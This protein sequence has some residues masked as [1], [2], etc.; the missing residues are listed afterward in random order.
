MQSS[1]KVRKYQKSSVVG[2]EKGPHVS[3]WTRSKAFLDTWFVF[4]KG[5]IFCFAIGQIVQV[6][7]SLLFIA[8]WGIQW[9]RSNCLEMEGCPNVA[10]H[11]CTSWHLF[12][13]ELKELKFAGIAAAEILFTQETLEANAGI[14]KDGKLLMEVSSRYRMP[15]ALPNPTVLHGCKPWMKQR[16]S[17]NI[18]QEVRFLVS[19]LIE[20]KSK[21][22]VGTQST[23]CKERVVVNWTVP[24][25]ITTALWPLGRLTVEVIE[26]M[27]W[28]GPYGL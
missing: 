16:V 3:Q 6:K 18:K 21:E 14:E 12:L 11:R 13:I 20:T 22:K 27:N 5:S 10:C 1:T 7:F 4:G 25:N 15:F 9:E 2:I 17:K 26:V 24:I 19:W 8:I 23:F 28:I